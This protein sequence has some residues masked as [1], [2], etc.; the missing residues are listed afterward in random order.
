VKKFRSFQRAADSVLAMARKSRP[1]LVSVDVFD[2]LVFRRCAPSLVVDAAIRDMAQ[3]AGTSPEQAARARDAAYVRGVGRKVS[4]GFDQEL[5]LREWCQERASELGS[6]TA[7][8]CGDR[9]A[10]D[11]YEREVHY[12]VSVC[13]ANPVMLRFCKEIRLL[14]GIC[15][16]ISC[17]SCQ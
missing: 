3:C 8:N 9:V 17:P 11:A 15:G 2:T 16:R 1:A 13:Y 14:G 6:K 5:H 7:V 12:E 4:Q 10:E